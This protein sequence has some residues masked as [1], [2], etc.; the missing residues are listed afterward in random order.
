MKYDAHIQ[1]FNERRETIIKW[2]IDIRGIESSQ[3]IIGDNAS[4]AICE[5]LS[6]YL[7]KKRAVEEGFQLNHSWFKSEGI[8]E[9]LPEF[10]NKSKLI[11]KMIEL[12]KLCENLSYGSPKP[13]EK[14]KLT[15]ELFK[16]LESIL[17]E[18]LK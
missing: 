6:A 2:A 4:K 5:L 12:E 11:E 13:V 9:R 10:E 17:Q 3:R 1:A 14:I 16:Y 15:L 8:Y 18:M 7:H